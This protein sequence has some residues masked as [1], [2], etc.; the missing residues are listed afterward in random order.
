M[1][2]GFLAFVSGVSAASDWP[3]PFD[4]AAAR[5]SVEVK[6]VA[7]EDPLPQVSSEIALLDE[8]VQKL[9]EEKGAALQAAVNAELSSV[10]NV[11]GSV[12]AIVSS[13][14]IPHT[15][16]K[17]PSFLQTE[18]AG[19]GSAVRVRVSDA[20]PVDPAV[21]A[22]LDILGEQATASL[23]QFYDQANGDATKLLLPRLQD[24]FKKA[25]E[26]ELSTL[27]AG[28][29]TPSFLQVGALPETLDVKVAQGVE[30]PVVESLAKGFLAR[31]AA[32][33]EAG[34]MNFLNEEAKLI[35]SAAEVLEDEAVA[36]VNTQL[37]LA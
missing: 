11:R 30:Y 37:A 8:A 4:A 15:V 2:F 5:P 1:L 33:K 12:K 10:D 21:K 18:Q 26:N 31:V 32:K 27:S 34:M 36:A 14:D 23:A 35:E 7:P 28:A 22:E 25:L 19:E 20:E 17:S 6:L 24:Q 29:A 3:V 16:K 13:L 9:A